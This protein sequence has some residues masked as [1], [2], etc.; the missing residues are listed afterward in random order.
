[1]RCIHPR[2]ACEPRIARIVGLGM[3]GLLLGVAVGCMSPQ[4]AAEMEAAAAKSSALTGQPA[5]DFTLRNQ[6]GTSVRLADRRGEWIV[7]YFYPANGT[8]GCT[9][10]AQEFTRSHAQFQRLDSVVFGISPDTVDSHRQFTDEFDLKVDLLAD[11]EHVVMEPYGA[12][13]RTPFGSR[14]VR[15]TVLIDPRGQVAYHWPEVIPEGHA[16]RVWQKLQE[17]R[18]AQQAS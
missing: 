2:H 18:A 11:P 6:D 14:V 1:M 15:S 10:Q 12:W 5:I 3:T 17:L 7:L 8:P 4:R 16:D 9:C 13:V